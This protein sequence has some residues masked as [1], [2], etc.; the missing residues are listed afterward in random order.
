MRINGRAKMTICNTLDDGAYSFLTI[1]DKNAGNEIY[2][3]S[4]IL[5]PI[6]TNSSMSLFIFLSK[7]IFPL[8]INLAKIGVAD[9]L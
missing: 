7:N 3:A 6:K 9:T 2:V 1:R 8:L 4:E 5:I